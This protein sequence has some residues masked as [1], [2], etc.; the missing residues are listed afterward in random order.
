MR[1]LLL[2]FLL[3]V[4]ACTTK[5]MESNSTPAD[6]V[7]IDS[8]IAT[9]P[10]PA[11]LAYSALD[12]FTAN[13]NLELPDSTNYF[14]LVNQE[15]LD[16]QF[17]YDKASASAPDFIINYVIAAVCKPTRTFK[18]IAVEKVVTSESSIDVYLTIMRDD[19]AKA[20]ARPTQLFAIERRE[21]YPV[22]QFYVNGKKDKAIVLVENP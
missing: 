2:S 17:A 7:A 19:A 1:T 21:G 10:A 22:M 4:A 12:G 15:Q 16:R 11:L 9:T 5:K 14:Y 18:T 6:S 3:F 20:T 13:K 8:V